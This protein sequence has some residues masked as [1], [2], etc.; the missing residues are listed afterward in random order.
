M[1][2]VDAMT[3]SFASPRSGHS[4]R[5]SARLSMCG[6]AHQGFDSAVLLV[7]TAIDEQVREP[8]FLQPR[9]QALVF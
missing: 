3:C 6:P 1:I 5:C 7:V 8:G 2:S 4:P 9:R